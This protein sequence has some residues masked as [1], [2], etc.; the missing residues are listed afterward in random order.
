[1]CITSFKRT[2]LI[3]KEKQDTWQSPSSTDSLVWFQSGKQIEQRLVDVNRPIMR[4]P[5]LA[6]HLNRD[7]GSK[8]EF[9]KE[10]NLWVTQFSE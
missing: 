10:T 4:V 1:M 6:I 9:N 3:S 5:N 2:H 8:F 7:Y